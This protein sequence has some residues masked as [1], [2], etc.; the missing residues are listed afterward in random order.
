MEYSKKKP[1]TMYLKRIS[2]TLA[3][4]RYR[5]RDGTEPHEIP[6]DKTFVSMPL[7]LSGTANVQD[8]AGFG[9]QSSAMPSLRVSL[10]DTRRIGRGDIQRSD[11]PG[12]DQTSYI[13]TR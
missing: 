2:R 4:S 10:Y 1:K 7:L 5:R 13:R 11:N 9:K 3:H 8:D 6:D 12:N